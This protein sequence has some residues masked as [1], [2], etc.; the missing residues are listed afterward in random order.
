MRITP[1][2]LISVAAVSLACLSA[3]CMAQVGSATSSWGETGIRQLAANPD[4][5]RPS[6]LRTGLADNQATPFSAG[7]G[8]PNRDSIGDILIAHLLGLEASAAFE[9]SP[10]IRLRPTLRRDAIGVRLQILF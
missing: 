5:A 8:N 9:G 1:T 4:G 6:W 3:T 10:S 7:G 2:F